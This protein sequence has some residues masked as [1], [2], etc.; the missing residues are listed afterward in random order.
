[1]KATYIGLYN[2]FFCCL[3]FLYSVIWILCSLKPCSRWFCACLCQSCQNLHNISV[4]I[5]CYQPNFT[6]I[7]GVQIGLLSFK[8]LSIVNWGGGYFHVQFSALS[9]VFV[10]CESYAFYVGV[11]WLSCQHGSFLRM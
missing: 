6:I 3:L 4:N 10:S 7:C 2:L 8:V 5:L 11:T 1:M 9:F